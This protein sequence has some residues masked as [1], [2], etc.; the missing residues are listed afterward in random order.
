M[1]VS[2]GKHYARKMQFDRHGALPN[3]VRQREPVIATERKVSGGHFAS[4]QNEPDQGR[5]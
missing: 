3:H 1:H 5:F 4:G 2:K